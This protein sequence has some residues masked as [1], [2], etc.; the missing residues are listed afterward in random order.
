MVAL[1]GRAI[2]RAQETY[3]SLAVAACIW[4][5]SMRKRTRL[6]SSRLWCH[7]LVCG[8][9][10]VVTSQRSSTYPDGNADRVVVIQS[11][12]VLLRSWS[13]LGTPL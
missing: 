5:A 6:S 11:M 9:A 12:L 2:N 7:L 13:V 4:P 8:M 1:V 3:G 10:S